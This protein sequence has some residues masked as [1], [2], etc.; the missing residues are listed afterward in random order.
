M[1]EPDDR[2]VLQAYRAAS[3]ALDEAP[4]EDTREAILAAARAAA[5]RPQPLGQSRRWRLPLAAAA[6]VLVGTIAVML[7]TQV[8]RQAPAERT[9][10]IAAAPAAPDA[11]VAADADARNEAKLE[12]SP[13]VSAAP[14]AGARPKTPAR[15]QQDRESAP[16][17]TAA[18]AAAAPSRATT[19]AAVLPAPPAPAVAGRDAAVRDA[20]SVT[21]AKAEEPKESAQ[22]P[23]ASAPSPDAGAARESESQREQ[24]AAAPV[25]RSAAR[26]VGETRA[27]SA[28]AA[29]P[30]RASPEAWI[31]R[32]V[33]LRGEG[34]HHE[35][36]KELAALR[37]RHP[38]LRLPPAA[39][40]T[41]DR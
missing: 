12:S 26:A 27:D 5:A 34:R 11:K 18:P 24:L 35:A 6:S 31:E 30:W 7:A 38:Q 4:A 29:A 28:L 33:L 37:E 17:T 40:P 39:L 19:E 25:A 15:P 9:E 2:R 14:D 36:D 8:E 23:A 13:A 32:I 10:T 21:T 41:P 16:A 1:T 3:V 20:A 22:Q